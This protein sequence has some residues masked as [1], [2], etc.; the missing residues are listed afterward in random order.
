M[1]ENEEK[2]S[3]EKKEKVEFLKKLLAK[4]GIK[5]EDYQKELEESEKTLE[6]LQH[7]I[8]SIE[9]SKSEPLEKEMNNDES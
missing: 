5:F 9:V 4:D 3:K 1:S 7:R 6:K 8:K 2:L